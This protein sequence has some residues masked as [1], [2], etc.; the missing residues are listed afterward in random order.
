M[1]LTFSM[2][3]W[4]VSFQELDQNWSSKHHQ[5][6]YLH[7]LQERSNKI[8]NY[9]T[10]WKA[11]LINWYN[12]NFSWNSIFVC[13]YIYGVSQINFKIVNV[14]LGRVYSLCFGISV[15]IIQK[16][17]LFLI[18]VKITFLIFLCR[19]KYWLNF[20]LH[21]AMSM[22][23]ISYGANLSSFGPIFKSDKYQLWI[24][25]AQN[26][27][28]CP[29]VLDE[30]LSNK[31]L[32]C[33]HNLLSS[34]VCWTFSF[35]DCTKSA[36]VCWKCPFSEARSLLLSGGQSCLSFQRR[37]KENSK[38]SFHENGTR[39]QKASGSQMKTSFH[40]SSFCPKLLV[41]EYCFQTAY[42]LWRL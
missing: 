10:N 17:I 14:I 3:T 18:Q 37:M 7:F 35:S 11:V 12:F 34:G 16:Y 19:Q 40:W 33:F 22:T 26:W 24:Q 20:S 9:N 4:A 27:S 1:Y 41:G 30:I 8:P 42:F 21:S 13:K 28:R 39:A 29:P 23:N 31:C 38:R 2:G 5:D 15:I 6:V 32:Q 36:F 25:V